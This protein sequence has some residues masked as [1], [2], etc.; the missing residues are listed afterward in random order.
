MDAVI[1][2]M[3]AVPALRIELNVNGRLGGR[4]HFLRVVIE[5]LHPWLLDWIAK[6]FIAAVDR[7]FESN[8]RWIL[9]A[10]SAKQEREHCER[11]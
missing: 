7:N 4:K 1:H 2:N 5:E 6:W 8:M 3:D 9:G 10:D 11:G